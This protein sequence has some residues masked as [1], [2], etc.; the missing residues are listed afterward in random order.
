MVFKCSDIYHAAKD[1]MVNS[2]Y[3][4]YF[5]CCYGV[6]GMYTVNSVGKRVANGWSYSFNVPLFP[7]K[8]QGKVLV[9]GVLPEKLGVGVGDAS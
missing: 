3:R 9:P 4:L 7:F 6:T 8:I 1:P 2:G 5:H